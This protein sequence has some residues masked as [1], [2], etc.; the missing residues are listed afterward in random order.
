MESFYKISAIDLLSSG[1]NW[2]WDEKILMQLHNQNTG[3]YF[4]TDHNLDL[5]CITDLCVL[6]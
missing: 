4:L 5:E 1:L 6:W 2:N 3:L